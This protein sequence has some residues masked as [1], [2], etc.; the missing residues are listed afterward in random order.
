MTTVQPEESPKCKMGYKLKIT[1]DDYKNNCTGLKI[2]VLRDEIIFIDMS[3]DLNTSI[4]D[5]MDRLGRIDN[6]NG[7]KVINSSSRRCRSIPQLQIIFN[8][9][10]GHASI[11]FTDHRIQFNMSDIREGAVYLSVD[12]ELNDVEFAQF[13][14]ELLHWVECAQS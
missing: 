9:V 8:D 11:V 14:Q 3:A 5:L 6:S 10:D 13:K 7:W 12:I 4:T 1:N 2:S